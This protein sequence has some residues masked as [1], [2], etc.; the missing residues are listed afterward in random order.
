MSRRN[1]K[2]Y[3]KKRAGIA[4]GTTDE[5]GRRKGGQ[6]GTALVE[7]MQ[8]SPHRDIELESERARLPVKTVEAMEV[9]RRGET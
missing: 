8:A 9:A 3:G 7:A 6:T 4:R 5:R 2:P 1:N